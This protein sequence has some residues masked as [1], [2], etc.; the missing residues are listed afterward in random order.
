[1][2]FGMSFLVPLLP[3]MIEAASRQHPMHR[4]LCSDLGSSTFSM[5]LA[6]GQVVGP[7]FGSYLAK[8]FSFGIM[9]DVFGFMILIYF[10][11]Y[12]FM[13]DGLHEFKTIFKQIRKKPQDDLGFLLQ[14][15]TFNIS[16]RTRVPSV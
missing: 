4:I 9:S 13:C 6:C 2:G 7:I 10:A 12:F 5:G 11:A 3:E 1:M 8:A 15:P 14:S 16:V